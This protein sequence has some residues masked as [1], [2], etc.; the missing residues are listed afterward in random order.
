MQPKISAC[1]IVRD[2]AHSLPSCF[3]SLSGAVDEIVVVDTG[4]TDN[5]IAIAE[6]GGARVVKRVWHGD[7]AAARNQALDMASGEWV[8]SIDADETLTPESVDALRIATGESDAPL[9]Y[10]VGLSMTAGAGPWHALPR[11]FQRLP[12]VAWQ[13]RIHES[14]CK[15]MDALGGCDWPDSGVRLVHHGE[16]SDEKRARNLALLREAH[17]EHPRDPY[18]AHKLA[19]ALTGEDAIAERSACHDAMMAVIGDMSTDELRRLP[20]LPQAIA[21]VAVTAFASG[22]PAAAREIARHAVR[23]GRWDP[24]A[25]FVLGELHR[26]NGDVSNAYGLLRQALKAMQGDGLVPAGSPSRGQIQRSIDAAVARDTGPL[27]NG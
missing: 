16:A 24:T 10:S 21:G 8:L 26:R 25:L 3:Q 2:E 20:W 22:S 6:A 27:D 19:Q 1:L 18:L 7:F 15:S 13:G 17:R 11:L 9:G 5:T 23:F 14:V 12:S 4:S